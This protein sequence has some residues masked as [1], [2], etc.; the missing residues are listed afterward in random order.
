MRLKRLAIDGF[1]GFTS[2]VDIDMDADVIVIVAANGRG[3]TSLLDAILWALI[4][5]VTRVA[6]RDAELISMYSST[7]SMSVHVELHDE[8][9]GTALA[10]TRTFDGVTTTLQVAEDGAEPVRGASA[11]A[12]LISALW[13]QAASAA[14]SVGAL[15]RAITSSVYLQQ[16][17]LKQFIEDDDAQGRYST[18]AELLGGGR[19][20][21]VQV[22][23][24]RAK[25]S[26]A[27]ATT[28]LEN[29][30]V[31][32]RTRVANLAEELST[33]ENISPAA[34]ASAAEAWRRV[35]S[36]AA[37]AGVDG[38]GLPDE[39]APGAL[40]GLIRQAQIQLQVLRQRQESM[41]R[42]R[43][44]VRRQAV[45]PEPVPDRA[46][47]DSLEAKL[48]DDEAMLDTLLTH[49]RLLVAERK[50]E[51][52]ARERRR[53]MAQ[54]ALEFV[55]A[56]CPVCGQG[57]D[58]E[59]TRQRLRALLSMSAEP[60]ASSALSLV[61]NQISDM[62]TRIEDERREWARTLGR[63]EDAAENV[64]AR[65][66]LGNEIKELV[67][68][69]ELALE[70]EPT[71]ESVDKAS[72]ELSGKQSALFE[73]LT[74]AER[75][76]MHARLTEQL[77]GRARV[78]KELNEARSALDQ[79]EREQTVRRRALDLAGELV[80][81]LR[82]AGDLFVETQLRELAPVFQRI[83][84]AIDAHPV[85]RRAELVTSRSGRTGLLATRLSDVASVRSTDRPL[86]ILSSSQANAFAISL[87]LS[88]NLGLESP[89]LESAI[90]DD[91]LQSLD[92]IHLLGV[93]DVLR[94]V[95]S[96]RQLIVSTHDA[97]FAALLSR[98]LRPIGG[99]S[100][101]SALLLTLGCVS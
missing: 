16:D 79:D 77:A 40:D 99:S 20:T 80:P 56:D 47:V 101:S 14:D 89:P 28:R 72:D 57:H 10:V 18:V 94:R 91:P 53:E 33:L 38:K 81:E 62:E 63:L 13:P 66:R 82:A 39:P 98:K 73:L 2:A 44:L 59:A 74:S 86:S 54:L 22:A 43:D 61:Q 84:A 76:G 37:A 90:L 88:M 85:L 25:Q 24:E 49:A 15:E 27:A 60:T 64:A 12:A 21:D 41:E 19:I 46:Q 83:Y 9:D 50:A 68:G 93:V 34:E 95:A 29:A 6:G 87:F 75:F 69:L 65:A 30:T 58:H 100:S 5:R 51:A 78:E 36:L 1:R 70:S 35:R 26:Y 71:V 7:G 67:S 8:R 97:D 52:S 17:L 31:P 4:G 42:L 3:K 45:V 96:R 11:A 32:L 48:N 23:L 55:D 92:N